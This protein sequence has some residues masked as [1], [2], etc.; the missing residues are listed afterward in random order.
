VPR[1]SFRQGLLRGRARLSVPVAEARE[2]RSGPHGV[3]SL[4]EG[5]DFQK[6]ENRDFQ[7]PAIAYIFERKLLQPG[8]Q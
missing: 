8:V 3:L 7:S 6:K 1:A 2:H 5:H 4:N